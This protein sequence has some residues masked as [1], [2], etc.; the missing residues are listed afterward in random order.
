[1]QPVQSG[2]QQT[3]VKVQ[4]RERTCWQCG[5]TFTTGLTVCPHDGTRLIDITLAQ[6]HDPLIG[7]VL[8]ERF[9]IERKIGEGGMGNVYGAR[10]GELQVAIKVLKADYLRD[11]NIRRR[12]MHEA[13]IVANLNHPNAVRLIDFGQM[14]DGNFFMVMELLRGESLA[15]RLTYKFLS[16]REVFE[17]IAPICEVLDEAHSKGVIH[18]DLKPENIF[19]QREED[20]TESPRLIDFGVAKQLERQTITRTGTL[21]GTPAYMSPEQARGDEIAAGADA[22]AIGII[23]YELIAGNLPFSA[24]TQMGYALKH[25]H[26]PARSLL[27][28]PGM[29]SVPEQLDALDFSLLFAKAGPT[30]VD[31]RIDRDE[32]PPMGDRIKGLAL[33]SSATPGG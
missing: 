11:E 25:M 28:L 19:I 22:Y 5:R 24:T 9:F 6:D 10:Q 29:R 20:A 30:L 23:L 12:F 3:A 17:L 32:V 2:V 21:W 16:Y 13:R 18:R 33:N 14:P 26:E 8:D 15:E 27:S 31:V 7:Q 4:A 1:M